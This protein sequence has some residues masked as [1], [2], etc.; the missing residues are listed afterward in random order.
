MSGDDAN[1]SET[2][3]FSGDVGR[4]DPTTMRS[5]EQ[6]IFDREPLADEAAFDDALHP[7]EL[8]ISFSDGIGDAEWCRLDV[9][10]YQFGA[11][12]FHYVDATGTNWRFDRHPNPHS[13]EKHFHAPPDAASHEAVE[14]CI[15]VEEP[16]LVVLAVWKL[17]RRAYEDGDFSVL[18]AATDPP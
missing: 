12:R 1:S 15:E 16:R 6:W 7:T 10:W 9:T 3:E 17:W 8:Q 5:I 2:E 14:S 4:P 13:P 18:N 11:Y